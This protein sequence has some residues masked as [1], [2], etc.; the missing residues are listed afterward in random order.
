MAAWH[1]NERLSLK[2]SPNDHHSAVA[3]LL[4]N[5][6]TFATIDGMKRGPEM[7]DAGKAAADA[8]ALA[9]GYAV[10]DNAGALTLPPLTEE[11]KT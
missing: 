4:S 7:G 1:L 10:L 2:S 8:A 3:S 11:I 9:A 6:W 5:R